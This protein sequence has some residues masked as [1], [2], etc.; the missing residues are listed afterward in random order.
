MLTDSYGQEFHVSLPADMKPEKYKLVLI[1]AASMIAIAAYEAYW[2]KGLFDSRKDAVVMKIRVAMSLA[3]SNW[4]NSLS[5]LL[6]G[7]VHQAQVSSTVIQ[8]D[9]SK[10]DSGSNPK[11]VSMSVTSRDQEHGI[12]GIVIDKREKREISAALFD[13]LLTLQLSS[14][15]LTIPHAICVNK[16]GES[17]DYSGPEAF[18]SAGNP[19]SIVYKSSFRDN[20]DYE[21]LSRP[22]TVFVLKEMNVIIVMSIGILLFILFAFWFMMKTLRMQQ[23]LAEMK[24]DFTGNITHELKTPIAVAYAAN[25]AMLTYGLDR[26][27]AKREQY[28]TTTREQLERLSGMVEQILSMTMENRDSLRLE[29]ADTLLRPM[30]EE[31]AAHARLSAGKPCD[32]RT[33]VC[34]EDLKCSLDAGMM[35]SVLSTL[36]DN[37]LKYSGE[38]VSIL[39]KA[40]TEK[41]NVIIDVSD[42]GTGI[43][44]DCQ[45]HVFDK[46]YRIPAGNVQKV[47]GY[48]I[49][50][51]FARTIVEK[52]GG[53][54]SV[55]STPG[56]GS[57]FRITLSR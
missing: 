36:L 31:A 20:V 11:V 14:L 15:N 7:K 27:P 12:S 44:H 5:L 34:P 57:T 56:K 38:S 16:D 49:G 32:I 23:E 48:G 43:P 9:D 53:S 1:A 46:F 28:L 8:F 10:L 18:V 25:D 26:D 41:G 54:I 2:L 13:S 21:F 39:I 24:N 37:S 30:L 40:Y 22:L 4:D 3:E 19:E 42:N 51:F 29:M 35:S 45:A 33:D 55:E 50:L 6:N 52:H 17:I 47:R